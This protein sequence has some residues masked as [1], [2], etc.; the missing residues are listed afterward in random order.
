MLVLMNVQATPEQ[1][2]NVIRH[3]R[4]RGFEPIEL[5]GIDRLAIGVLG[6][7]PG[8]IRDAICDLPGVVDAIPVSKPYKQV[9]REWHPEPTVVDVSGRPLRRRLICRH[10]RTVCRREPRAGAGDRARR[11]RRGSVHVPRRARSSLARRRTRSAVS[12]STG[13]RHL[14]DARAETGLPL[15]TEV[16]TPADVEI[17]SE[18]ADM[19]QVGHP[20]RA[21]L[22]AARGCRWRD[23]GRCSSSEG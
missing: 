4:E 23:N 14:A 15:V 20:Q 22:R 1:V 7:N 21:E 9:T 13:L 3:V 5:P 17:V 11:R 6:S 16:L 10:R 2:A 12:G 18:Y 8:S 19:L